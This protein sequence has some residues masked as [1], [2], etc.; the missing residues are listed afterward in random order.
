MITLLAR[1][2]ING[3]GVW[4]R[5]RSIKRQVITE[6]VRIALSRRDKSGRTDQ[7]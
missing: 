6:M 3:L 1:V 5:T 2:V 4:I 7:I